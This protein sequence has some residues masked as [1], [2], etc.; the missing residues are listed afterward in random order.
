MRGNIRSCYQE[1]KHVIGHVNFEL[2]TDIQILMLSRQVDA[3]V[4]RGVEKGPL[5]ISTH[6]GVISAWMAFRALRLDE[7]NKSSSIA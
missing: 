4:W 1:R 7:V 3:Q 5:Y 6:L 2:P